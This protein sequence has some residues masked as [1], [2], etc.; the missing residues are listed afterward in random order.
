MKKYLKTINIIIVT[1]LIINLLK[2]IIYLDGY[3]VAFS[4]A[5]NSA[6]LIGH[7]MVNIFISPIVF[8]IILLIINIYLKKNLNFIAY[9]VF[10][11]VLYDFFTFQKIDKPTA[12]LSNN[13]LEIERD[14][15]INFPEVPI[16]INEKDLK[17]NL[18]SGYKY[19]LK[20][21]YYGVIFTRTTNAYYSQNEIV[22]H[23]YPY[24]KNN[25]IGSDYIVISENLEFKDDSII[26]NLETELNG[27]NMNFKALSKDGILVMLI[28]NRNLQD[29]FFKITY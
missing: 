29:D 7:F 12:V 2:S 25:L 14:I 23:F 21:E 11:I 26:C 28:S 9:F 20:G 27:R 19:D 8:L 5:D 4:N 15:K 24:L 3:K 17:N 10:L 6:M 22:N 13:I 18:M 16:E 1:S